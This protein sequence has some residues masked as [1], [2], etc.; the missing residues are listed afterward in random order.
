MEMTL[1][2]VNL[3]T[4]M[5]QLIVAFFAMAALMVDAFYRNTL[6]VF[7][8][9]ILGLALA[10]YAVYMQCGVAIPPEESMVA[11]NSYT[12]FFNVIF[13]LVAAV[14]MFLSLSYADLTGIDGGK[15]YPL[16]LLATLGMMLLISSR[17]LLLMFLAIELLSISSYV[18]VASQR[19]RWMSN[20]AA[21]KYMLTGA[22]ASA[23]LLFGIALVFGATGTMDFMKI[24]QALSDGPALFHAQIGLAMMLVG[25][26]FKVAMVPFHMW[27]P[28]V[29]EGAPT[30]ISGFLSAGSKVAVFAF[31]LRLFADPFAV[32][33]ADWI[34]VLSMVV[35]NVSALLQKSVKRMLAYSSIAHV[36][37]MLMALVI[38][39]TRAIEAAVLYMAVYAI[40]GLAAFGC[41]ACLSKGPEERL[42]IQDYTALA[43]SYPVQSGVLSVCLLSLAG[44]PLTA[45]FIGKFYLFGAAVN[46]GFVGLAVIGVL[47]SAVSLYY[48]M[49]LMLRMYTAPEGVGEIA[50]TSPMAGRLVLIVLGI[51]ILILGIYPS[52]VLGFVKVAVAAIASPVM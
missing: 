26:G 5:P 51:A 30:P 27:A 19:D 18:L 46:A 37:Y 4:I 17:D 24:K 21:I 9:S 23:F 33:H 6:Y 16:I 12:V 22:F 11:I 43:Y 48:Y 15:Y 7:V 2:F 8:V 38:L 13:L 36:G 45:G 35:G 50:V 20:E 14:T 39:D 49:G 28:D 52:P 47:N 31:L 3:G 34:A 10:L 29:Y 40:T 44:I 32:P 41:I 1:P 25:L 42:D